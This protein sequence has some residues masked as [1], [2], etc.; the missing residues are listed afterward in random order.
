MKRL[1]HGVHVR[2]DWVVAHVGRRGKRW[3]AVQSKVTECGLKASGTVG[4]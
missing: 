2:G 3:L 4:T 1:L